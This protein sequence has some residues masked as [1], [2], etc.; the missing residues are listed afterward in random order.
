MRFPVN[1]GEKYALIA[2]NAATD[3]KAPQDLGFG[4]FALPRGA[5]ELPEHWKEWLG[6]TRARVIERSNLTLFI[7]AKS[8]H[9]AVLD[10]QN[11]TLQRQVTN[12]YWGLLA[13]DRLSLKGAGTRVT[14]ANNGHGPDVSQVGELNG[15][16]RVPGTLP[17]KVTEAHLRRATALALNLQELL[18]MPGMLRMKFAIRTFL[19]AFA[20]H[21]LG[22]RIHQFVRAVDGLTRVWNGKEF[23]EKSALLAGPQ[24]QDLCGQLYAVRSSVEHFHHPDSRLD[25]L[26]P[27][28]SLVRAFRYALAAEALARH[29]LAHLVENKRLWPHFTDD[30]VEAFWKRPLDEQRQLWGPPLD[31]TT[32]LAQFDPKRVPSA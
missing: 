16:V 12:L 14:G 11:K 13:S 6:T 20:E 31:L 10:G 5:L 22:E 9:P 27:R 23:K 18:A 28:E 7:K 4:F 15:I 1:V 3:I 8:K 24:H 21:D 32:T 30:Q 25:A 29:C 26:P 2:L 19:L 17:K